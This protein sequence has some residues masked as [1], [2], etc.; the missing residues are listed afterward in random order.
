MAADV[1]NPSAAEAT[2][3]PVA[4]IRGTTPPAGSSKAQ[5]GDDAA[6]VEL[7]RSGD[8]A[9]Y[10]MLVQRHCDRLHAVMLHLANGDCE[11]AAEFVQEAFIRAWQRLDRFDGRCVFGTWLYR[12]ARNRAIDLLSRRRDRQLDA[13]QG[14]RAGQGDEPGRALERAETVAQVQAALTR[15]PVE[16]RE[17]I[18]LRDFEDLDYEQIAERLD[19]ALGTV[20]SRLSRARAALRA[21]LGGLRP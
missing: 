18:L 9:A 7:A 10:A 15:L 5:E 4:G 6:L 17:I 1:L 20:K 14:E 16:A 11:Q 2:V 13:G 3:D 19:L 21:E 8:R 12:L